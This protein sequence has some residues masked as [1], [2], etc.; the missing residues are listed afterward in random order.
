MAA[1][2]E[3]G[4]DR[5]KRSDD[6]EIPVPWSS[7]P[8]RVPSKLVVGA[9]V[10]VVGFIMLAWMIRDHDLRAAEQLR[11]VALKQEEQLR[12]VTQTQQDIK[13]SLEAM[14]WLVAQPEA[15][16]RNL[17][18]DMPP[19]IRNQLLRRTQRAQ[20]EEDDRTALGGQ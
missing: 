2:L 13:S 15:V 9:L 7:A 8:A 16:R 6:V 18:L 12:V 1:N 11:V 3:G 10:S 19:M 4:E 20:R 14:V 5:T 17:N